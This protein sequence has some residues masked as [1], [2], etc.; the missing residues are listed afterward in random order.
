[1]RVAFGIAAGTGFPGG[2][3]FTVRRRTVLRLAVCFVECLVVLFLITAKLLPPSTTQN[4]APSQR[5]FRKL[6]FMCF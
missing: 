5:T 1:L 4:K 6:T 2:G 3:I